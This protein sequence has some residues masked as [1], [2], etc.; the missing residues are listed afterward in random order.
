MT[1][2]S[3][4]GP[5]WTGPGRPTCSSRHRSRHSGL[6]GAG[7]SDETRRRAIGRRAGEV[8]AVTEPIVRP[9]RPDDVPETVDVVA[10]VAAEGIWLGTPPGF[11][12]AARR[13]AWLADL[14]DPARRG[15]V[16]VDPETGWI[17]GNGGVQIAPYGVAEVG[18]ALAKDARGR[19]LGGHLLDAL[20]AAAGDLGAHK[21]FLY[22]WPHNEAALR[23]Y[24]SR[25]FAVEGRLRSHYRRPDGQVWDCIVMGLVL[26]P[27]AEASAALTGSALPDAPV[28]PSAIRITDT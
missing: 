19:G 9:L 3:P 1:T 6:A 21:V 25:G 5:A 11:D 23:L 16:V 8:R 28:L 24:L 10:E 27:A 18:M 22:V 7:V 12:K 26:D 17:L 13:D 20:I 2:C 4:A 15:F 14:Q